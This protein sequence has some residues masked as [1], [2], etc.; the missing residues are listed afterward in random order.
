MIRTTQIDNKTS[1]PADHIYTALYCS[2]CFSVSSFHSYIHFVV[3]FF[4]R[5]KKTCLEASY[6]LWKFHWF[7]V[8]ISR[9]QG[10]TNV[11]PH[12]LSFLFA[13]LSNRLF[14][15][16]SNSYMH[17]RVLQQHERKKSS[18]KHSPTRSHIWMLAPWPQSQ[19]KRV[20][21]HKYRTAKPLCKT[22]LA[23]I[24]HWSPTSAFANCR[25]R[26]I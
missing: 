23:G 18:E 4:F 19:S 26:C 5:K 20:F 21:W 11:F 25:K 9:L 2:C 15:R 6:Y 8:H 16:S 13:L 7:K 12:F 3:F 24:M 22:A 1:W 10:Q 17:P 14:L